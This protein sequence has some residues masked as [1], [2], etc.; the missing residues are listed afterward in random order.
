M[1]DDAVGARLE[2]RAR[3]SALADDGSELSAQQSVRSVS[4]LAN[5]AFSAA[6][7]SSL[8]GFTGSGTVA[9]GHRAEDGFRFFGDLQKTRIERNY[10][11]PEEDRSP[12]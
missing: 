4:E 3:L 6:N 5:P 12:D 1:L 8:E 11:S 10:D 9:T 7:T 2:T